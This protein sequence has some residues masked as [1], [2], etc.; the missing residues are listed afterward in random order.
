MSEDLQPP[1]EA[2]TAN[3][4]ATRPLTIAQFTDN[5][6]PN[7]S[8]LLYAVQFLEQQILAAGHKVL[9]VAPA[10]GGPNPHA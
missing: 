7:H 4:P 3:L 8:G 6:G 9:L 2:E 10:S 1:V 5:Y